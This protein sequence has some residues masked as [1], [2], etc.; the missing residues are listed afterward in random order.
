MLCKTGEEFKDTFR[1]K[2]SETE[3]KINILK[4]K[5]KRREFICDQANEEGLG[6]KEIISDVKN[7]L[8]MVLDNLEANKEINEEEISDYLETVCAKTEVIAKSTYGLD[9]L[10][11]VVQILF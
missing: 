4:I 1:Y 9:D 5:I 6:T 11:P 3:K 2:D 8:K 7:A 10:Q